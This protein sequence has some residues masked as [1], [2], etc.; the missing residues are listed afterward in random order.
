[1][2]TR[3]AREKTKVGEVSKYVALSER[4]EGKSTGGSVVPSVSA[5]SF[6]KF[7]IALC[8]IRVTANK[9]QNLE[10]AAIAVGKAAAGGASLVVLP[11]CCE[12]SIVC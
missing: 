9:V 5:M 7:T 10:T 2:L 4:I 6:V 3:R 11:V 1:M 12:G 8:Q